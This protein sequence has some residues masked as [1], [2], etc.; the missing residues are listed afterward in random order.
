MSKNKQNRNR[1]SVNVTLPEGLTEAAR[2][3][4]KAERTPFSRL[5]EKLLT[6]HL[7]RIAEEGLKNDQ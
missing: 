4:C 5:V 1:P 2:E 3:H 7:N 6:E